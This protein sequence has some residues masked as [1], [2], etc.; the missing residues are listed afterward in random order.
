MP[1]SSTYG[2][3]AL[4]HFLGMEV[5]G[6]GAG[7]ARARITVADEHRNPNG[8][9]HGAVYFAMVDTAMGAAT[10]STLPDGRYCTSVEVQMRFIRPAADGILV[11]DASVLKTGRSVVHLEARVHDGDDRLIATSGGTFAIIGP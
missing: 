8:V 6:A 5:V 9:V 4:R 1:A 11:A 3:F 2:D 7:H 10:M